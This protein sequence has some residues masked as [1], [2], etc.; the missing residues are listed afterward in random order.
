[1]GVQKKSFKT[2]VTYSHADSYSRLQLV[3]VTNPCDGHGLVM[4]RV[5]PLYITNIETLYSQTSLN[6][7]LSVEAIVYGL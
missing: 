1:M 6:P 2:F 3:G 4:S 5:T 7:Y